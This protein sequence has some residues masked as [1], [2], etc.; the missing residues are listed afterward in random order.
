MTSQTGGEAAL[1]TAANAGIEVCFANAGTT[2]IHLVEAL[3]KTPAVRSILGLFE[4]VC[5]GA[6]DGYAR[7]A[8]KPAL[9][10]F[11]LGP[12][13]AN[14]AANQ[15]NARRAWSP[16]VN[17][18]GDQASWHLAHDAPLTSDIDAIAGW[19][20]WSRR[21]TSADDAAATVADAISAA[22]TATMG[23]A[24][25]ILAADHTWDITDAP[26][27]EARFGGQLAPDESSVAEAAAALTGP[28]TVLILAGHVITS[29]ARRAAARLR[30]KTGC[31]VYIGGHARTEKGRTEPDIASL[32]YFPEPL[33]KELADVEVAVLAGAPE[34]VC[35][36]GYRD[37]PS[38]ALPDAARRVTL[39]TTDHDLEAS[40][41]ALAEHLGASD[42][43]VL[44]ERPPIEKPT[45]ELHPGS[46]AQAV[47]ACLPEN[48]IVVQEA[49]T[50]RAALDQGSVAAP[51]FTQLNL[52]GGAI[53]EGLPLAV[54]AAVAAPDRRVINYQADGSGLYTIQSLWTMAREQLDITVVIINNRKYK[55][56]EVE[57]QRADLV[58][59][60]ATKSLLDLDR[61][62]INFAEIASGFGLPSARAETAD[63]AVSLLEAANASDGP[64]LID[65]VL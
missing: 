16:V 35:F 52:C 27:P 54:G 13:F 38:V 18:I 3:D 64:F 44:P 19:A 32:P 26:L 51:P 29:N 9:G 15:H 63:E 55:I 1:L 2:E 48:A 36:F 65:A 58:P 62:E 30:H 22:T 25:A 33:T 57:A 21:S 46:L 34:P 14:S 53:G 24:S 28:K 45:G 40:L 31:R 6:A 43:E 7:I 4:G 37:R 50:S 8:G 42:D 59:G 61:P 12:G 11:H 56:I 49:I 5:S 23:P 41:M 47:L 60:D 20:G 39:C 17:L 10:L